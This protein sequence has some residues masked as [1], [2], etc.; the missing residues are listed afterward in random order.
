MMV[1]GATELIRIDW[2]GGGIAGLIML[3]LHSWLAEL[4]GIPDAIVLLFAFA[5]LAYAT[6]SFT[7]ARLI[8]N[9]Q[10]PYLSVLAVANMVWGFVC[11]GLAVAWASHATGFGIAHFVAEG[12]YVGGLGFCE[13]RAAGTASRTRMSS[14]A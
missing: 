12:L 14:G 2:I 8:K 9:G 11:L 3:S 6:A 1:L 13:W 10:V 7:L 5:N 4:Y